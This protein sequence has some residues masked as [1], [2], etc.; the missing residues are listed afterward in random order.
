[1]LCLLIEAIDLKV[2]CFIIHPDSFTHPVS[3]VS[4]TYILSHPHSFTHR[5]VL[6]PYTHTSA[7]HI[8]PTRTNS[9]TQQQTCVSLL[10]SSPPF[11]PLDSLWQPP[12]RTV[13]S[14]TERST[15]NPFTALVII[16]GYFMLIHILAADAFNWDVST[17]R[18]GTIGWGPDISQPHGSPPIALGYALSASPRDS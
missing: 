18:D 5:T 13:S 10:S 17:N 16:L 15:V 3:I 1:V 6:Y 7:L 2:S 9:K 14:G 11:L 12:R 8:Q 4:Y